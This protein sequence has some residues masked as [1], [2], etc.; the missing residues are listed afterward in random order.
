MALLKLGEGDLDTTP[1]VSSYTMDSISQNLVYVVT[2]TSALANGIYSLSLSDRSS[3][4]VTLYS[5]SSAWVSELT[6]NNLTGEMAFLTGVTTGKGEKGDAGLYL[7]SPGEAEAEAALTDNELQEG[8]KI[9]NT[10]KM[11]WTRDG[12][13]L[14]LGIKPLS[15]III[16][17][18]EKPDSLKSLYSIEDI[19]TER[20]V[21]VWHWNDPYIIPN[22]KKRWQNEKDRIYTGVYFWD[23]DQFIP[24][25]DKLMPE[26]RISDNMHTLRGSPDIPFAK[27]VTWD[28]RYSDYYLV[29][30][31][32]GKNIWSS[33]NTR[34]GRPCRPMGTIWPGMKR[35]TGT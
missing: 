2:D 32:E 27:R 6:W 14:F 29:D 25:A 4:P 10:G 12:K 19:L 3:P 15:E 21:D 5:D 1:F 33:R 26:I 35:E 11:Q 17:E 34:V 13:R 23:A 20:A 30:L 8:W 7:W 9:W 18:K 22:H 31:T 16:P 28:G 24:L